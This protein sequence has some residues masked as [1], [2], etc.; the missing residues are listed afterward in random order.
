MDDQLA[1]LRTRCCGTLRICSTAFWSRIF[2][3][4]VIMRTSNKPRS[5]RRG[6]ASLMA[7]LYLV[8]FATLAIGFYVA[9]TLAVQ[10]A[11]N[12]RSSTVAQFAADSGLQ[13]M[14]YQLGAMTIPPGTTSAQLL[15]T[16]YGL[17]SAS[18][19]GSPNM[20]T[21]VVTL[22]NNK[23][24]V[25]GNTSHFV[26][27]DNR[28]GAQFQAVL[29][30][31]GDKIQCTVVGASNDSTS[32]QRGIQLTFKNA[33]KASAIFNYGIATKGKIVTGGASHIVGDPD[34]AMGS[35]LSTSSDP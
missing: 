12:E 16:T 23:I 9:T 8:L 6:F 20:G 32:L 7:M 29:E 30:Q 14:R 13:F 26:R 5:L 11:R 3:Q 34:P 28:T 19:N 4:E 27:L 10:V 17:L 24:Y 21:D 25:P 18:L 2:A 31:V 15:T 35:V 1:S 33:P 22:S